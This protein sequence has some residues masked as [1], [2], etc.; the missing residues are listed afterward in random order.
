MPPTE[1]LFNIEKDMYEM[2][3]LVADKASVEALAN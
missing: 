2:K 3:N 1:E